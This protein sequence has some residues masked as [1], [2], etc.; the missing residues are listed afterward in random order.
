MSK[1]TFT[2][3]LMELMVDVDPNDPAATVNNT[4]AALRNP[5]RHRRKQK[6][7]NRDQINNPDNDPKEDQIIKQQM[8][9]NAKRE[10]LEKQK[11]RAAG[12]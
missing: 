4:K 7:A 10:R 12:V 1:I 9:L 2:E 11:A 5:E 8:Q 6:K 3:F